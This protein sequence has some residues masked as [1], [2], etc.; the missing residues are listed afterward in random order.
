MKVSTSLAAFAFAAAVSAAFVGCGSTSSALSRSDRDLLH[1]QVADARTMFMND[2]PDTRRYF[3]TAHAYVIF[4]AVTSGAVLIGGAGGDGEVY[5]GGKL[6]GTADIA[7]ANIGAQLGGQE[8]AEV[9]FFQ[10]DSEFNE[11]TKGTWD[12]D[13]KASAVAADSGGSST[14]DYTKGVR[15]F[16]LAKGGLMAQAAIGTQKLRYRSL[17]DQPMDSGTATER[18]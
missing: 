4:P 6:I 15:V 13:A 10:N 8:F 11:F 14:A 12:F 5:Q 16:T 1:S 9:I 3:D 7:Q 18:P 17:A 2:K